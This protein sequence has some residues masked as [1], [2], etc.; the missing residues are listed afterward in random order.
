[1]GHG[2]AVLNQFGYAGCG[3]TIKHEDRTLVISAAESFIS[4]D[5][6]ATLNLV[7]IKRLFYYA[8]HVNNGA[9]DRETFLSSL[10]PPARLALYLM[11]EVTATSRGGVPLSNS[12]RDMDAL[13]YA[14]VLR[15]FA[16]WRYVRLIPRNSGQRYVFGMGMARR[17]LVQNIAK[18]EAAA[19]HWLLF[20]EC[21]A[22]Q[23]QQE[24]DDPSQS[25]IESPTIRQLLESEIKGNLHRRLPCLA[26]QSAASGLLWSKRQLQYQT[27]FFEFILQV[28]FTYHSSKEAVYAAYK[29][30]YDKYHGF[31]VRQ[32]FH[33]SFEAAPSADN[34]LLCVRSEG[35][36]DD[37]SQNADMSDTDSED[38]CKYL[39]E[40]PI[41]QSVDVAL[42]ENAQDALPS[43]HLLQNMFDR[44]VKE[45]RIYVTQCIGHGKVQS[46]HHSN[47]LKATE[48]AQAKSAA[49]NTEYVASPSTT[50]DIP[51]FVLV[52]KPLL[53]ELDSL[54]ARFNMND[55]TKV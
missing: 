33:S 32:V 1:M 44:I 26:D 53:L 37:Y 4:V 35:Q 8:R 10:R 7:D 31:F 51:A 20:H 12:R 39:A 14:A 42:R 13:Y 41:D 55:P 9:F 15:I 43:N 17:D 36:V 21:S 30:T 38:N 3:H 29:S 46:S 23:W 45:V 22:R 47:V 24:N 16:E 25:P 50:T 48:H 6:I 54:I 28:P 2:R 27:S 52:V 5:L 19:H 40:L 49:I 11:D 18:I 34:I